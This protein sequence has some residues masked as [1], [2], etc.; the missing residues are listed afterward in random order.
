ML[1]SAGMKER[2][3]PAAI[4][5]GCGVIGLTS[6]IRLL[7]AGRRVTIVP[8][9]VHQNGGSVNRNMLTGDDLKKAREERTQG[10]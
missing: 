3:N 5:I 8:L 6:G 10:K 7:E 1:Q 4:V 9:Q 2:P